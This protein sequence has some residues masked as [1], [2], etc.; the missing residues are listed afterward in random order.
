M[1]SSYDWNEFDKFSDILDEYLPA[2]G[3]GETMAS[4]VATAVSK[5]VYKWFNDGDV[6]DNTHQLEGW[7]NDLSTYA[8]WLYKYADAKFLDKIEDAE[9]EGD[10]EDILYLL[11][12]NLAVPEKLVDWDNKPKVDSVYTC[13]GPFEFVDREDEDD[14]WD[15]DDYDEYGYDDEDIESSHKAIKSAF[16]G[17]DGSR[18]S[19]YGL[20]FEEFSDGGFFLLTLNG[21]DVDYISS[22]DPAAENTVKEWVDLYELNL[23]IPFESFIESSRE[24]ATSGCHGKEKDEDGKFIKEYDL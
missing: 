8:N 18:G 21:R 24:F 2:S 4:Q 22:K 19:G 6:Y 12:E 20:Y 16:L 23:D 17:G 10:Y 3:E 13:E 5:L 9:S 11:C 14:D 15:E 1:F 7:A